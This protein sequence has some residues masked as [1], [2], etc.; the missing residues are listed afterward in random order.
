MPITRR[1]LLYSFSGATALAAARPLGAQKSAA[2]AAA[3]GKPAVILRGEFPDPTVVRDGSDFYMTHSHG[4]LY[5]P[6]LLIWHSKDLYNWTPVGHALQNFPQ[7]VVAP[8]LIKYKGLFYLYLP[9]GRTNYV[10]TASSPAGPWSK[11]V[12]LNVR[13]IDPGHV[14]GQDGKRYLYLDRGQ[15]VSLADDGLSVTGQ[16]TRVYEGWKF[17]DAW[18]VE[19]FCLESPKLTFHNGYYYMTSAQG[20]TAGP[21]TSHMVVS[22]RSRSPL[23]PWENS[24]YNPIVHTWSAKE[25]WWSKG[26]GTLIDDGKGRWYVIYHAYENGHRELGRQTLIESVE[27]TRDGWFRSRYASGV[28]FNPVVIRNYAVQSDDFSKPDLNLQWAFGG[29]KLPPEHR[30]EK[31]SVRVKGSAEGIRAMHCRPSDPN[32]E[33][34]FKLEAP[35]D[36]EVG[37]LLLFRPTIEISAGI[38]KRGNRIFGI[39]R[40][41]PTSSVTPSQGCQYFKIQVRDKDMTTFYSA[42]GKDWKP[43]P[44]GINIGGYDANVLGGFSSLKIAAYI[45]GEGE[46]GISDFVYRALET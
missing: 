30:L 42:D 16:P 15:V 36:A 35:S 27:W 22:A 33:A 26:H 40:G 9:S 41:R 13:G 2:S 34:S 29:L 21:T 31:G 28:G 46:L 1:H 4:D 44:D 3:Q 14:V 19:C 25:P 43:L 45:K 38:G 10:T 24:P 23:G 11:P 12:D 8:D 7:V 6:S 37:V 18:N 20:G 17:P 32:Y 39:R 5:V